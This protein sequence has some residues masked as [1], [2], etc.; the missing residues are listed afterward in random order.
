M[1]L[2]LYPWGI[3]SRK[4]AGRLSLKSCGSTRFMDLCQGST[5][6]L[7]AVKLADL[8]KSWPNIRHGSLQRSARIQGDL[9]RRCLDEQERLWFVPASRIHWQQE[10][11]ER[12]SILDY[13]ATLGRHVAWI[14]EPPVGA[15]ALAEI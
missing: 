11:G 5:G 12:Y 2:D 8:R 3:G 1:Q 15:R 6:C 7:E 13:T 10:A 9:V 14:A 4:R